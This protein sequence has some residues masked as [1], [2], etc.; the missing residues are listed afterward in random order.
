MG[1]LDVWAE[2]PIGAKLE[3]AIRWGVWVWDDLDVIPCPT[4]H[5]GP[6]KVYR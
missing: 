4:P 2:H 1:S 5:I 3:V 6:V